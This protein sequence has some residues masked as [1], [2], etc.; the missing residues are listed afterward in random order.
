MN[1]SRGL[2]I[3]DIDIIKKSISNHFLFTDL[4][5]KID[6]YNS[7]RVTIISYRQ[8]CYLIHRRRERVLLLYSQKRK[9]SIR[10]IKSN[11]TENSFKSHL[12]KWHCCKEQ[13]DQ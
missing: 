2:T 9:A 7:K 5:E 12:V 6:E 8:R 4:T 3:E 10:D 1:N 11:H 13:R